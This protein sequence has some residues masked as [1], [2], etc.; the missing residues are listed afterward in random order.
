MSR[1]LEEIVQRA[2]IAAQKKLR[3]QASAE[4]DSLPRQLRRELADPAARPPGRDEP[5]SVARQLRRDMDAKLT[6]YDRKSVEGLGEVEQMLTADP[7]NTVLQDCLAFLYYKDGRLNQA[8]A[9]FLKLLEKDYKKPT[10][11]L[12]LGNCYYRKGRKQAAIRHWELCLESG[13][14][15]SEGRKARARIEDA[16]AELSA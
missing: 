12:Y 4:R 15:P 9:L 6:D 5:D 3:E 10:Q 13:P 14:T 2:R 7:D 11:H 8:I 16:R 1:E